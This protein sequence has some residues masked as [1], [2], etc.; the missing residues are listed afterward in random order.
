MSNVVESHCYT[1]HCR[2]I[3]C[4]QIHSRINQQLIAGCSGHE[5]LQQLQFWNV[6]QSVIDWFCYVFAH[7]QFAYRRMRTDRTSLGVPICVMNRR[8]MYM[9]A[10]CT[11]CI[12]VYRYWDNR[13]CMKNHSHQYCI[14]G[15]NPSPSKTVGREGESTA[16]SSLHSCTVGVH[17]THK[18]WIHTCRK[19]SAFSR[20]S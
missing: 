15:D 11:T 20:V 6:L 19:K 17:G 2:R 8:A 9:N 3:D 4:E 5:G 7:N 14:G 13:Q 1:L 10:R 18:D 16:L 12:C